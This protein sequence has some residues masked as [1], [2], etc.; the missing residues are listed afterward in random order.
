MKYTDVD[1]MVADKGYHERREVWDI[2]WCDIL[3]N[4]SEREVEDIMGQILTDIG[5]Y[6]SENW[7]R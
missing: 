7:T 5:K 4:L 3:D 1:G 6:Q 2:L